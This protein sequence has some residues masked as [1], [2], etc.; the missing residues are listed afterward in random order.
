MIARRLPFVSLCAVLIS[1]GSLAAVARAEHD[2]GDSP[3]YAKLKNRATA[4][5]AA[6]IDAQATL[7]AL[8]GKNDPQAFSTSRGATL[9]GT[10][11]QVEREE[12]GDVH[13]A[14]AGQPGETS[15]AK[16]V[17]V[18]V[19][20]SWQKRKAASLGQKHLQS[21]VGKR[22]RVTGWLYWEPDAASNDPRGTRWEL[23]PVTSITVAG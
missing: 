17:I 4:P 2:A 16:W 8:L 12:D 18:E 13:L 9:E 11:F 7:D 3:E 15:T 5:R 19:T 6:S 20:P 14:L 1:L 10:V 23:H 22:V 21:L